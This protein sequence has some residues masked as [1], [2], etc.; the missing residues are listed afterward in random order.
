MVARSRVVAATV[1]LAGLLL[2]AACGDDGGSVTSPTPPPANVS[3]L[4]YGS[5][6][7]QVVRKSDGFQKAFYCPGQ[8]TISTSSTGA[9]SGFAVVDSPC[10][11]ESYTLAGSVT[12]GGAVE[13]TT[14]APR[15]TEGPCPGGADVRFSGQITN[16]GGYSTLSARGVTTVTCPTF[17]EHEYTYL[18]Y[19][20]K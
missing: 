12:S 3:G 20:T 2:L 10:A 13:Y 19:G 15:P 7:L 5:W 6:T 17:G 1:S 16:N 8:W 4:Y 18:I 11:P 14:N 9:I